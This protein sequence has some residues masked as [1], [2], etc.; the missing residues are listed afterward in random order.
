MSVQTRSDNRA[1]AEEPARYRGTINL[2]PVSRVR[3][4][5]TVDTKIFLFGVTSAALMLLSQVAHATD[6]YWTN[7]AG[8]NWSTAANWNTGTLPGPSDNAF[9]ISNGNYTVTLDVSTTV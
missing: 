1:P 8:G 5:T 9:I 2:A 6:V 4:T 3:G 7:T